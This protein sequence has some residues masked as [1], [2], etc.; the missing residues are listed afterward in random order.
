MRNS[1]PGLCYRCK[2]WCVA[3]D[4]HFERFGGGWR[5]QHATCAIEHRGTPDP[6]RQALVLQQKRQEAAGTGR[7]ANRARKWLAQHHPVR[8]IKLEDF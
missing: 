7:R 5:V 3:G 2:K 6:D 1:H 8:P 4:G